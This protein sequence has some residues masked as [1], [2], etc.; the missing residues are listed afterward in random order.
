[1]TP[2]KPDLST[3]VPTDVLERRAA[4]QRDR[5]HESVNELKSSMRETIREKLDMRGY[6]REHLWPLI[7]GASV[8]AML[9]GYGVAGMF[10]RS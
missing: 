1:M 3:H 2:I 9:T 4:E 5:I 8:L 7:A 6:A 10:T